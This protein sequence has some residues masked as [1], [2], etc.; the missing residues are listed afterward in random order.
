[1]RPFTRYRPL[2]LALVGVVVLT[3]VL[4]RSRR[5]APGP[6]PQRI[7]LGPPL[8]VTLDELDDALYLYV[9][10]FA[11]AHD[12]WLASEASMVSTTL[13]LTGLPPRES[14]DELL[15]QVPGIKKKLGTDALT[16]HLLT[17][18]TPE[19]M[20]TG[21]LPKPREGRV[22]LLQGRMYTQDGYS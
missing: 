6:M 1:M 8:P 19:L 21:V 20:Q 9:A 14:Q 18:P 15:E 13:D 10:F 12:N 11:I 4:T 22:Q 3:V 16:I 2:I 7:E 5:T 17:S